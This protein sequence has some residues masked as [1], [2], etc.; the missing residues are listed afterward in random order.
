MSVGFEDVTDPETSEM[1]L[2]HINVAV[3]SRVDHCRVTTIC[4][5]V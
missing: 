3:E 4:D 1:G 5:E 2:L